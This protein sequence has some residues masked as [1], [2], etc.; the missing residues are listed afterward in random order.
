MARLIP[1]MLFLGAVYTAFRPQ[2]HD[3]LAEKARRNKR[4]K[5]DNARDSEAD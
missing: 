5:R 2:I 4:S 3:W 1:I